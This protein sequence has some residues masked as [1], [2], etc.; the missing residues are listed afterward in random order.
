MQNEKSASKDHE[1]RYS[2][3]SLDSLTLHSMNNK[4]TENEAIVS[5]TKGLKC[6]SSVSN[7]ATPW[8]VA[9]QAP[10][11][12]EISRQEYWSGLPCPP[13]RDLP[14]PGIK[15]MSQASPSLAGRFFTSA[16]PEKPPLWA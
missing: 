1:L 6:V 16:P 3:W 9:L 8:I 15:P 14:N 10:L 5:I 12:M 13:P 11:A 7:S 2:R 4:S